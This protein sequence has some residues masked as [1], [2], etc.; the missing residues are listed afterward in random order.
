MEF[1]AFSEN[2]QVI[3][4]GIISFIN[5]FSQRD[6]ALKILSKHGINDVQ[7]ESWYSQQSYFNAMK[8]LEQIIG[9]LMLTKV[10][11]KIVDN[12][13]LQGAG[14]IFD[15]FDNVGASY[16]MNNKGD[17]QSYYKVT[18]KGDNYL[19]LETN[20]PYPDSF[21]RGLYEGFA[22]KFYPNAN[23]STVNKE[24]EI[25]RYKVRW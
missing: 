22:K 8:E 23:I 16:K 5:A 1:K 19:I 24:N 15:F 10:G 25:R 12:V 2:V 17:A 3:G 13:K 14:N 18:E 6:L 4:G 21:D 9:S 7:A 20:N 11:L